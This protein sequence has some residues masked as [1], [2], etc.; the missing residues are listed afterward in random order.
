VKRSSY[1]IE[2]HT[3]CE[4]MSCVFLT[5][6][7]QIVGVDDGDIVLILVTHKHT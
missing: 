1:D 7:P 5:I 3:V 6:A 4:P 2:V